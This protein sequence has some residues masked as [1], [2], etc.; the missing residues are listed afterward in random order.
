MKFTF[1]KL[2]A[3]SAL[4]ATLTACGGG[5]SDATTPVTVP[6]PVPVP[7]PAIAPITATALTVEVEPNNGAVANPLTQG[8]V[9]TGQ[10]SSATDQDWYAVTAASA[11]TITMNFATP[12]IVS[13]AGWGYSIRDA[14]N[15]TLSAALCIEGESCGGRNARTLR[16]G[17][18]A[19]GTYYLVVEMGQNKYGVNTA[20][21]LISATT[22]TGVAAIEMEINNSSTTATPI[23]PGTV[24]T[25]QLSSAT[26]QD[27]YAVTAAS[28][29]TIT[30][31]FLTEGVPNAGWKYS[32]RDAANNILSAAICI[33]GASCSKLSAGISAAGTYYLV[34]ETG[35]NKYG[36]NTS[37][38]RLSFTF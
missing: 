24:L 26:D 16:A 35:Q 21:Y 4:F 31:N 27:W 37:S 7:G 3:T 9:L 17:I 34:V 38:Y 2:V 1:F 6:V 15:N 30:M 10:L 32:I 28:A 29:G 5:G 8:V 13:G 36:V 12:D 25:G 20:S 11:G 22:T 19:A 23:T 33:N 14:A 18:P